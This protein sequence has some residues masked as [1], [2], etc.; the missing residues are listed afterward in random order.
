MLYVLIDLFRRLL[1]LALFAGFSIGAISFL[2]E[3]YDEYRD[4]P[5]PCIF[6][7]CGIMFAISI[8]LFAKGV[9]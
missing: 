3:S 2:I 4:L 7:I 5:K 8:F 6:I 1:Y 9:G